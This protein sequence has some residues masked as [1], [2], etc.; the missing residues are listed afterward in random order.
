M[1]GIFNNNE[2]KKLIKKCRLFDDIDELD[3]E[4]VVVSLRYRIKTFDKDEVIIGFEDEAK[5][6]GIVLDG[7]VEGR[8]FNENYNE[9]SVSRCGKGKLFANG[10]A[11]SSIEKSPMEIT[12]IKKSLIMF[13]DLL[14]IYDIEDKELQTVLSRNLT[15]ILSDKIVFLNLKV[16]ILSQKTLR[17]K[18]MIYLE[19][20]NKDEQGYSYI[21]FN[22]TSLANFLGANRSSL[23]KELGKMMDEGIIE[24]NKKTIKIVKT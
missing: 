17:D 5:Y 16:R 11:L 19:S 14:R 20:L 13:V 23:V 8:F 24:K 3:Y 21:P 22:N 12:A 1:G 4:R 10:L 7:M 6:S 18:L 9:I 2:I 15:R